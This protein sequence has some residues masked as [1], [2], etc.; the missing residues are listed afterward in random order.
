MP[1]RNIPLVNEEIYHVFNRSIS[2][3]PTFFDKRDYH[4]LL[5]TVLYYQNQKPTVKLSRF[6]ILSK[7][8]RNNI[9]EK[10]KKEA[11][12][13]VEIICFCFMPNHLHFLL[14]QIVDGGIAKFMSNIT[15]SYTRYLNT[16]R[17]RKGPIFQGKFEAVRIESNEQLLH[18]SRY[19]HLNP[20][21]SF[22][23]KDVNQLEDYGYSSFS[24]YIGKIQE[25]FCQKEIVLGQFKNIN[26]Y[27]KFIF[28]QV[29]YQRNL[30]RI[31][32][33]VLESEEDLV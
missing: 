11:N 7:E 19:I 33:L 8:Q 17:K 26:D 18:V 21:T 20:L 13:L 27:K 31:K 30:E 10:N 1:G 28:D 12:F 6:L 32:H 5:N 25:G 3:Q 4:R 29:D 23:I 16:K 9:L 2:F 15:N 24:E 22:V 14:K